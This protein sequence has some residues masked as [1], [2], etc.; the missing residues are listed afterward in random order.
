MG[1]QLPSRI[2]IVPICAIAAFSLQVCGSERGESHLAGI[3]PSHCARK[4]CFMFNRYTKSA[5]ICAVLP[6]CFLVAGCS[7]GVMG[8]GN[9]GY[10]EFKH[11]DYVQA[12][13]DFTTDINNRPNSSLAQF[14]IGD[15]YRHEGDNKRA[16]G[17]FHQAAADGKN[18]VPD[19]ILEQGGGNRDNLT[20]SNMACRHLHEDH[21]LDVNCDDRMAEIQPAPAPVAAAETTPVAVEA[22]ATSP[23]VYQRKQDRN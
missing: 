20:A 3:F 21:Q 17:M 4:W 2:Q 8:E 11:G 1:P 18:T 9:P 19:N 10:G 12:K 14:N 5:L 15:S 7:M 13:A 16:D 22:E 23:P 6:I